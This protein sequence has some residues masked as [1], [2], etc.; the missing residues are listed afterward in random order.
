MSYQ[1]QIPVVL[2]GCIGPATGQRPGAILSQRQVDL[3]LYP[4]HSNRRARSAPALHA[5]CIPVPMHDAYH[6]ISLTLK[7]F[8]FSSPAP[9]QQFEQFE[10]AIE[11]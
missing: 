8:L 9:L 11:A 6:H 7:H 5:Q 4:S 3:Q 1:I 2:G 10:R